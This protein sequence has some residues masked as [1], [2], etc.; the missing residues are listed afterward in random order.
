MLIFLVSLIF[1][2]IGT[3]VIIVL[4]T[5]AAIKKKTNFNPPI[6]W[7]NAKAKYLEEKERDRH[8]VEELKKQ[9]MRRALQTI[10]LILSL[11]EEGE[12]IERLY[13]RGLLTDDMHYRV[14]QLKEFLDI[15]INEVKKES[16]ELI[17]G[18][19]GQIWQNALQFHKMIK[20]RL[21]LPY[22]FF[23]ILSLSFILHINLPMN[24]DFFFLLFHLL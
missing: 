20:G 4:R 6:E 13:S 1:F 12:S 24:H 16:E 9:L 5:R 21:N 17:E 22:H 19:S 11:Q 23:Q 14:K 3:I 7:L 2:V 15:E 10:P 8:N 18:W